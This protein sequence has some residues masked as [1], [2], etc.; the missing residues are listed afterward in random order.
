[1]FDFKMNNFSHSLGQQK[2][3]EVDFSGTMYV[4]TKS[5]EDY[6]GV[7]FGYQSNT[8]FYVLTWRHKNINLNNDTYKAGIKG[9]QIKV[10]LWFEFFKN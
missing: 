9:I 8:K 10:F 1:M 7:V 6:F 4:N 5:G 2:Y 3:G